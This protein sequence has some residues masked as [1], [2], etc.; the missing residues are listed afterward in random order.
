M[1]DTEPQQPTQEGPA[2]LDL[3]GLIARMCEAKVGFSFGYRPEKEPAHRFAAVVNE[4][5]SVAGDGVTAILGALAKGMRAEEQMAE[6]G[7]KAMAESVGRIARVK[8]LV[9]GLQAHLPA[10]DEG[11]CSCGRV[12]GPGDL[13]ELIVRSMSGGGPHREPPTPDDDDGTPN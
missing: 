4:R 10:D 7:A 3:A 6:E 5:K 1:P 13:L 9:P 2:V 8:E 11:P 12:H